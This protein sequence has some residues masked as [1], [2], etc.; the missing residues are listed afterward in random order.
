ME[1][2]E[3]GGDIRYINKCFIVMM[4][5]IICRSVNLSYDA[6]FNVHR[7]YLLAIENPNYPEIDMGRSSFNM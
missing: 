4:I 7:P 6:V 1:S 3:V 2:S 5:I